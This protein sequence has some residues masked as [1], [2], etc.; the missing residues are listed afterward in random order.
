MSNSIGSSTVIIFF[1]FAS[2]PIKAAY[3]VVLLPDPVGPTT[4]IMP[5]GLC[6][7]VFIEIQLS[8]DIPNEGKS[9]LM[10]FLSSKRITTRSP[11]LD[12]NTETRT[13]NALPAKFRAMR[14]SCGIRFSAISNL[15]ITF[16]R[17]TNN[18]ATWR[19]NSNIF[20]NTPSIRNLTV[21]FLSKDSM[22][23]SDANS[24]IA[25]TRMLLIN[26]ITGASSV[27]SNKSSSSDNSLA[28]E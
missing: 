21:S 5:W 13:S 26:F 7:C 23:I 9:N 15:A 17:D 8:F 12:G 25:S 28:K 18:S 4:K 19:C 10:L 16:I 3:N 24:L 2:I 1:S 11:W 20:L 14:P 6:T 27:T 22:C